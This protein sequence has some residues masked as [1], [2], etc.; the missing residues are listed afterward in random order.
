M[1]VLNGAPLC[2]LETW[3]EFT[4]PSKYRNTPTTDVFVLHRVLFTSGQPTQP[5]RIEHGTCPDTAAEAQSVDG[6]AARGVETG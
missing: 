2:T 3:I 1:L 5:L 6:G 4:C